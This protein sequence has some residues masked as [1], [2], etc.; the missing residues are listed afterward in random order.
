MEV[1][2]IKKGDL[3]KKTARSHPKRSIKRALKI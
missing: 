1:A 2:A 3:E